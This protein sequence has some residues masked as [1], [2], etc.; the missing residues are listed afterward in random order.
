MRYSPKPLQ[1]RV[2]R[3]SATEHDPA[4]RTRAQLRGRGYAEQAA[5]LSPVADR[6]AAGMAS[7]AQTLPHLDRI[8]AAFGKHDVSGI[9]AHMGPEASGAARGM[10]ATAYAS[11]DHV[12]SD[13][14]PDLFTAAHEAAHVVQQRAGVHLSGGVGKKGDPYE[15]HADAVAEKVV[16]GESAEALLSTGPGGGGGAGPVLQRSPNDGARGNGP[17]TEPDPYEDAVPEDD[18]CYDVPKFPDVQPEVQ[19]VDPSVAPQDPALAEGGKLVVPFEYAIPVNKDLGYVS[20][21]EIKVAGKVT[22]L[23]VGSKLGKEQ[24][25]TTMTH[26]GEA[27]AKGKLGSG[28]KPHV[29]W[30]EELKHKFST[31]QLGFEEVAGE[32]KLSSGGLD[33]AAGGTATLGAIGPVKFD[34]KPKVKILSVKIDPKNP[35]KNELQLLGFEAG[36][37]ASGTRTVTLGGQQVPVA[38]ESQVTFVFTPNWKRIAP[39]IAKWLAERSSLLAGEAAA[40]GAAGEAIPM[41]AVTLAEI[42]ALAAP[43]AFI[44]AT[45]YAV[46]RQE[47]ELDELRS[48]TSGW[49]VHNAM[50]AFTRGVRAGLLGEPFGQEKDPVG[51]DAYYKAGDRRRQAKAQFEAHPSVKAWRDAAIGAGMDPMLVDLKIDEQFS[52]RLKAD[53]D[54]IVGRI[55]QADRKMMQDAIVGSYM[56]NGRFP[57][58]VFHSLYKP[59]KKRPWDPY[60]HVPDDIYNRARAHNPSLPEKGAPAPPK[61]PVRETELGRSLKVGGWARQ[62]LAENTVIGTSAIDVEAAYL[63]AHPGATLGTAEKEAIEHEVERAQPGAEREPEIV[64]LPPALTGDEPQWYE[65]EKLDQAEA[66]DFVRRWQARQEAEREAAKKAPPKPKL[67]ER[68]LPPAIISEVRRRV[69]DGHRWGPGQIPHQGLTYTFRYNASNRTIKVIPGKDGAPRTVAFLG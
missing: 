14:A 44:A 67:V 39:Q 1:Q 57:M 64:S 35:K 69:R 9:K 18:T 15:R 25:G 30:K 42:G 51:K 22:P 6:A 36:V 60:H 41:T 46:H 66:G 33:L 29:A 19:P 2:D 28:G 4:G 27:G 50:A 61:R 68:A 47:G 26:G 20:L 40:A 56:K 34:F 11:G 43:I 48:L 45:A 13:G 10:G 7:S 21:K 54:A 31:P 63:A 16:K 59:D 38:L 53:I 37:R 32:A 49:R 52:A 12:V 17:G 8:Q 58:H 3:Q 5:A 23:K 55:G 65:H 24:S 62:Y